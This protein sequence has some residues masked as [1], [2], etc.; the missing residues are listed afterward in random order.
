MAARRLFHVAV[1]FSKP[2]L[3]AR[4]VLSSL[5]TLRAF[6]AEQAAFSVISIDSRQPGA[7]VASDFSGLSYETSRLLPD[8]KGT[9]YFRPDNLPL[10]SVFQ[11]LGVKSLRIGGNSV[12]ASSV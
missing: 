2:A 11:T 4:C 8:E 9:H 1:A 10:I 3:L 7:T 12:D 6:A 5:L